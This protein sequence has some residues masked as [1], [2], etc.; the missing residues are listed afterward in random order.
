MLFNA[1]G[2]LANPHIQTMWSTVFCRYGKKIKFARETFE[3]KDGDFLHID[4]FNQKPDR[5]IIVILHGLGGSA[6]SPYIQEM[7]QALAAPEYDYTC[8]VMHFRGC[9]G[10]SNRL[11][12][13]YHSGDTGDLNEL[14]SSLL[15]RYPG[16]PIGSIGY[17]L[18]GN[19]LLKWLGET[20]LANPLFA[21]TAISVPF[22]LE[23]T[24]EHLKTGLRKIYD[25]YLL[26]SLKKVI[27]R[28]FK[29]KTFPFKKNHLNKIKTV[30]DFDEWITAPLHG[31]RDAHDYYTQS[32]C[33]PFLKFIAKP[34]LIIQAKDDPFMPKEVLPTS[35]Q[36][37]SSIIFNLTEFGGHVGFVERKNVFTFEK[38]LPKHVPQFFKVKLH[39]DK[40]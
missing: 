36:L 16:R 30:H 13:S 25:Q 33:K 8:A 19:V 3:L 12:R 2:W 39:S 28:D 6:R 20:K 18:G 38:W 7:V 9:S 31:F 1:K 29:T 15:I 27:A 32:C 26:Q 21:A 23:L 11:L 24:V 37:S 22:D 34:C 14:V 35:H 4:W 5:P 10:V 40:F 17:S